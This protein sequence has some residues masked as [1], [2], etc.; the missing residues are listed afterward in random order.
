VVAKA[1]GGGGGKREHEPP[2]TMMGL[3]SVLNSDIPQR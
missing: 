2:P 3:I 1:K